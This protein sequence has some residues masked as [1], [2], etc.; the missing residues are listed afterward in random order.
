VLKVITETRRMG[1]IVYQCFY[2]Y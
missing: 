1:R 2:Q